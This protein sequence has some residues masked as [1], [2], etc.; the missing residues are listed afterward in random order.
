MPIC[1]HADCTKNPTFGT[2]WMS[3]EYC[4]KHKQPGMVAKRRPKCIDEKCDQHAWFG[5][6]LPIHCDNH[7]DEKE[8]D[9]IRTQCDA[10]CEYKT[11]NTMIGDRC[12]KCTNRWGNLRVKEFDVKNYVLDGNYEYIHNRTV[13]PTICKSTM[14]R[15]DFIV[16]VNPLINVAIEVDEHQHSGYRK[17]CETSVHKEL[18]RLISIFENDFGG[19]PL[20]II[21]FNPDKYKPKTGRDQADI[22]SRHATLKKLLKD[23]RNINTMKDNLTCYYLYYDGWDGQVIEAPIKYKLVDKKIHVNHSHPN[24]TSKWVLSV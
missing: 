24:G 21:R 14:C 11:P 1:Q 17:M 19:A 18:A 15:L 20:V 16:D 6:D 13:K 22:V 4:A 5:V 2:T 10:C 9:L 12:R 3:A 7:R 8:T 23:I